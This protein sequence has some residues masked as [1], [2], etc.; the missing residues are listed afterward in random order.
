MRKKNL[1]LRIAAAAIVAAA[2]A[3]PTVAL[4]PVR[5]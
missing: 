3:A 4:A 1:T 2:Y 5:S